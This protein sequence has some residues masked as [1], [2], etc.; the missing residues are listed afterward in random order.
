MIY[1]ILCDLPRFQ[2][3]DFSELLERFADDDLQGDDLRTAIRAAKFVV[4]LADG[5]QEFLDEVQN[6]K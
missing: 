5:A 6:A 2:E 4:D 1:K 3:W